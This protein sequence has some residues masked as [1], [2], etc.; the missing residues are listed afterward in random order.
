MP[1]VPSPSAS[2]DRANT[3]GPKPQ[4]RDEIQLPLSSATPGPLQTLSASAPK[5]GVSFD[6]RPAPK[7]DLAAIPA[8]DLQAQAL[9]NL[10]L[11]SRN[12]FLV[13]PRRGE[14]QGLK[15]PAVARSPL[16]PECEQKGE[17]V[18]APQAP[19]ELLVPVTFIDEDIV[20][21]DQP[22]EAT[23]ALGME[24]SAVPA[25]RPHSA[26]QQRVGNT[27]TIVPKRKPP[28]SVLEGYNGASGTQQQEKE[29]A[30]ESRIKDKTSGSPG[31]PQ[32]D[33]GTQLKKRYPT[34]HEIQVIGG[35]LSLERSCMS[36]TDSR[37]KKMKISFNET[38]LQ[39]MFEYPSESSLVEEEEEEGEESVSEGEEDDD[40][41]PYFLCIPRP[42][43]ILTPSVPTSGFSSYTPKHSVD[44]SKW[45][46]QEFSEKPLLKEASPP[47]SQV[48]L[49]PADQTGLSD[50]SSEPA[51]YF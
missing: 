27:F 34:V 12:S 43:S 35:Y 4:R 6:I 10:R 39:T 50:F 45:Q 29:G 37:R 14:A 9:A 40:D 19:Q 11:N 16:K 15:E 32:M 46:D 41:K 36:K 1:P 51:L 17:S 13:V 33:C 24:A 49:T 3:R 2:V 48:M 7:P 38:S 28:N 30:E 5:N 22:Q 25:S 20:D 44:F 23:S 18:T 47:G 31:E 42:T 21:L 26:L 8:Q